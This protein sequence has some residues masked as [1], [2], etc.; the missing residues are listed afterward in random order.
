MLAEKTVL[1]PLALGVEMVDDYIS[2]AGVTGCKD[3]HFEMLT[4]ITKNLAGIRPNIHPSFD[5]LASWE[6]DG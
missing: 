1:D 4:E 2:V 3:N 6:F 5:Y